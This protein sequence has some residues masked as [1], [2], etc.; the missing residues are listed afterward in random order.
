MQTR[1]SGRSLL[2][3][4]PRII[5]ATKINDILWLLTLFP[6]VVTCYPT[7]SHDS[8]SWNHGHSLATRPS[9]TATLSM[10]SNQ[11]CHPQNLTVRIHIPCAPYHAL[12]A[13]S[14]LPLLAFD[15]P[16]L[17]LCLLIPTTTPHL[18]RFNLEAILPIPRCRR[19]PGARPRAAVECCRRR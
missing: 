1:M 2:L 5:G 17:L 15:S 10:E 4:R 18:Q 19:F 14:C 6:I 8:Q 9:Y 7:C 13:D 11:P 16:P 3:M 12:L